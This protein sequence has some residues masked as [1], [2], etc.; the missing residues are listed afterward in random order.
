ME[1]L[2]I[3]FLARIGEELPLALYSECMILDPKQHDTHLLVRFSYLDYMTV[4]M[5]D[6]P[7]GTYSAVLCYNSHLFREYRG[8]HFT[9]LI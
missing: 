2:R 4:Y 9:S 3:L 5:Y 6:D 1:K 7:I 8:R